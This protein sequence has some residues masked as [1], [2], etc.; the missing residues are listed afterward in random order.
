MK[1]T[2]E[3]GVRVHTEKKKKKKVNMTKTKNNG[4]CLRHEVSRL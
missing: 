1:V 3:G 2:G 4:H